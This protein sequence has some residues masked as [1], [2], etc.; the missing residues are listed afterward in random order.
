MKKY[1]GILTSVVLAL[2]LVFGSGCSLLPAEEELLPPKLVSAAPLNY[3]TITAEKTTFINQIRQ[4]AIF[5]T[6]DTVNVGFSVDGTLLS[7]NVEINKKVSKGDLIGV[8][9]ESADY[10]LQ[11][12]TMQRDV[13]N[14]KIAL[15]TAEIN[16]SGGGEVALLKLKLEQEQYNLSLVENG[17]KLSDG[18]TLEGQKLKVQIA[19]RTYENALETAK[20][21]HAVS[22]SNYDLAM[23][24]LAAIQ[25]KYDACFLYA[26]ITGSCTWT[27]NTI[28]GGGI[29]ANADFASF[30][31]NKSIVL[32]YSSD[33]DIS[34]YV[35]VGT[36][37][38][39]TLDGVDY[40]GTVT[41]TPDTI[42]VNTG[43]KY[44]H[45][46][47][48]KGL[49]MSDTKLIGQTATVSLL[50][51]KREDTFAVD[52][53]LINTDAGKYYLTLL[54]D[55]LPINTEVTL[56]LTNDTQTEIVSGLS[57]GDQIILG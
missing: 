41:H 45:F 23:N 42:T 10:K 26:P 28:P 11:L 7:R 44:M 50:I 20:N 55:N 2:F 57:V 37:M 29:S 3:T 22:K 9:F 15:D 18:T 51:D 24:E 43:V 1:I 4:D 47:N 16:A 35:K 48:V 39:V 56:G 12:S 49:N 38:T 34:A 40:S 32:A 31:P 8:L 13:N 33:K 25:A 27:V 19:Q 36:E 54:I 17:G 53:Y 46:I 52:T 14:L 21:T 5:R 6:Y 30:T